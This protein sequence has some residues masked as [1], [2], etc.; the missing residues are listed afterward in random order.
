M[1]LNA[2]QKRFADEYVIDYNATQ[3]AIR[4]GYSPK[5]AYSMGN[6]LLK[7]G[8]VLARIR[9]NQIAIRERLCLSADRIVAEYLKTYEKC[10]GGYDPDYRNALH[11]LDMLGKHLGMFDP[12]GANTA[13]IT[14]EVHYG[15]GNKNNNKPA[16]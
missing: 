1:A 15:Y 10:S 11:A 16:V 13:P 9:E 5:T 7:K 6:K 8:E 2:Q 3:A 4:A 14:L 12:E